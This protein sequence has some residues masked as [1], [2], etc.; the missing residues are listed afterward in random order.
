MLSAASSFTTSAGMSAAS[1][2]DRISC[3][4]AGLKL[5]KTVTN[6]MREPWVRLTAKSSGHRRF[7]IGKDEHA[8]AGLHQALHLDF[9]L[10][11]DEAVGVV[12][13]H[14]GAVVQ[15]TD[16]LPFVL[17]FADDPEAEHLAGQN[18]RFHGPGHFMDVDVRNRLQFCDLAEV[19]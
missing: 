14:H 16:A 9:N 19:V 15:V 10:L 12:H 7:Y 18:R 3:A 4:S 2:R 5:R 11:A 1:S 13:H 6:C 17:A 8:R